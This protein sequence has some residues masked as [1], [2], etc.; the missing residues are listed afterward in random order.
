MF[1]RS[2]LLTCVVWVWFYFKKRFFIYLFVFTHIRDISGVW[3]D[4]VVFLYELIKSNR[5]SLFLAIKKCV[6]LRMKLVCFAALFKI[7]VFIL[8]LDT[9]EFIHQRNIHRNRCIS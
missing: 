9:I 6:F 3:H 7:S 2:F 5:R 1:S 4:V 8:L